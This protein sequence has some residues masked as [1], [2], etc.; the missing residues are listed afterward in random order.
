VDHA[1]LYR[2]RTSL[3][4]EGFHN[5]HNWPGSERQNARKHNSWGCKWAETALADKIAN[6]LNDSHVAKS[7]VRTAPWW[8]C[9]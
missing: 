1:G 9:V 6:Y 2:S 8:S 5:I 4:D 7:L 3:G